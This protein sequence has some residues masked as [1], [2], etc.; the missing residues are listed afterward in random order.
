MA[1]QWGTPVGKVGNSALDISHITM[2]KVYYVIEDSF[3]STL[4]L[5]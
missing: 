4:L 5:S 1:H 2:V 3:V